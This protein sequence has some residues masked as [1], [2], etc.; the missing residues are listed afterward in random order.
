MFLDSLP[1][2]TVPLR[3]FWS[4]STALGKQWLADH[5][6][7]APATTAIKSIIDVAIPS[8]MQIARVNHQTPQ[9]GTAQSLIGLPE[10]K[11]RSK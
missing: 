6:G 2:P 7:T 9:I 1:W 11:F 3:P 8:P 4:N 5:A 10:I